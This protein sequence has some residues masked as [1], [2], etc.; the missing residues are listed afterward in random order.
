MSICS[1]Y[2][3][4]TYTPV[5]S[6]LRTT[7]GFGGGVAAISA[8]LIS[9]RTLPAAMAVVYAAGFQPGLLLGMGPSYGQHITSI[10]ILE[11]YRVR[12]P[13]E[14]QGLARSRLRCC[15]TEPWLD[16]GQGR[17]RDLPC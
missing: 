6:L 1:V 15:R 8:A 10:C 2:P 12:N 7:A 11:T 3:D 5:F 9:Y 13:G 14:G 4:I 17:F 16:Q